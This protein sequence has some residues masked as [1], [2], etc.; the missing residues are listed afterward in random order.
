MPEQPHRTLPSK[1]KGFQDLTKPYH[2]WTVHTEIFTGQPPLKG[3]VARPETPWHNISC[4][5]T[6][7]YQEEEKA[8]SESSLSKSGYINRK[9]SG[10][11]A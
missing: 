10:K 8:G 11:T 3:L 4:N 6:V 5:Y 1:V 9:Q 2:K 7:N